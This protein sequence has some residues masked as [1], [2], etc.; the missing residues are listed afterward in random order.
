MENVVNYFICL[1]NQN[2]QINKIHPSDN[3]T[4]YDLLCNRIRIRR[5][6]FRIIEDVYQK[7][8]QIKKSHLIK[9]NNFVDVSFLCFY[10]NIY[11]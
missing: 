4:E 11:K 10:Y 7:N 5:E 9:T 8:C 3:M 2:K 6:S 1:F